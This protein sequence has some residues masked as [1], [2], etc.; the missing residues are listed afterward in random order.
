MASQLLDDKTKEQVKEFFGELT[1]PV[2]VIFFGSSQQNCDYC[3][4]TLGLLNEISELSDQISL[5]EY[6]FE[7]DQDV[8]KQYNIDKVPMTVIAG[9]N[10]VWNEIS[11]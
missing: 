1:N 6:D 8:A 9:V 5:E 4:E 10:R 2:K 11:E 3:N 7:K